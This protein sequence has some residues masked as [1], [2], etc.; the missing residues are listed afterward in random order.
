MFQIVPF[1]KISIFPKDLI[2]FAISFISMFINVIPEP[3]NAMK[4]FNI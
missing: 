4:G 2:T 1:N 3:F